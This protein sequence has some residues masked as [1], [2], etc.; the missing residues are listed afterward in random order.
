MIKKFLSATLFGFLALGF[1]GTF[2]ACD[3]Y[4]DSNLRMRVEAVENTLADLQTQI[5]NGAVIKS[6]TSSA[7][8]ITIT[9]MDGKTYNITNGKDGVDGAAGTPGSVVEIGEN[10]NWF[11]DGKDTGLPS[12]GE[13]GDKG[14]KGDQGDK[15][16]QGDKG[17][18]G[19][20]GEAGHT[21]SIYIDPNTKE[22]V[23]DGESTGIVAEGAQG[24]QGAAATIEINDE[25]YWVIN[26]VPT[27]VKAQGEQGEKGEQG[28][29]GAT[30]NTIYYFPYNGN[31]YR[32][33]VTPDGTQVSN[34]DT[35]IS[36]L[37]PGTITAIYDTANQ[38]LT[39]HNVEGATDGIVSIKLSQ[40]L[41]GLILIP[42]VLKD[43]MAVV[44]W[45][46]LQV[47]ETPAEGEPTYKELVASP[48]IELTYRL[49]PSNAKLTKEDYTFAFVES[50]VETRATDSDFTLTPDN[51]GWSV[52]D[53]KL[54]ISAKPSDI[55]V[56]KSNEAY[57]FALQATDAEG[58]TITSDYG[59]LEAG[60]MRDYQITSKP[61]DGISK[62]YATTKPEYSATMQADAEVVCTGELDLNTLVALLET[63][64]VIYVDDIFDVT[65]TFTAEEFLNGEVNQSQYVAIDEKGVLTLTNAYGSVG[66]KPLIK[67]DAKYGETVLATAYL[68]I[69]VKAQDDVDGLTVTAETLNFN[70][71][72][73]TANGEDN[74]AKVFDFATVKAEV[75]DILD[76]AAADFGT[77]YNTTPT[78]EGAYEG[79]HSIMSV[80][81]NVAAL[82]TTE[83]G[84][85]F[86]IFRINNKAK[87]QLE[88]PAQVTVTYEATNANY[89]NVTFV[90]PYVVTDDCDLDNTLP[91]YSG[92][93]E[94]GEYLVIGR[95][96]SGND[97]E[98]AG[99]LYNAYTGFED[100]LESATQIANHTLSFRFKEGVDHTG[101]KLDGDDILTQKVMLENP[102]DKELTCTVELVATLTNGETHPVDELNVRFINPFAMDTPTLEITANGSEVVGE[103]N[104]VLNKIVIRSSSNNAV[105]FEE[106]DATNEAETLFGLESGNFK[107]TY[108]LA[109]GET[110]NFS[111]TSDGTITFNPKGAPVV[112]DWNATVE[113]KVEI[114]NLVIMTGTVNVVV[115]P[116]Q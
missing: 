46:S 47:K 82:P 108:S 91:A 86:I 1:A 69:D 3:D 40:P 34:E 56:L 2:V 59:M 45:Y 92:W 70:Y 116:A 10:G 85:G 32:V 100:W 21:P 78:I 71:S 4:D 50:K 111:V 73:L 24:A 35:G 58:H 61:E 113:V 87:T 39:M 51:E 53:G 17:D 54:S 49:N 18:K 62:T 14:D 31:W 6:V 11:I 74:T 57:I 81:V 33:E 106:G 5:N 115:K 76:I 44:N 114:S 20:T 101:I 64:L 97:Y 28:E 95:M 90:I 26:G 19:D 94:N 75:Y 105:I 27:D 67:V 99:F 25:G 13:K 65:Y 55:A 52:T 112:K 43:G 7:D 104:N 41:A 68:V 98:M 77:Y 60:I 38:V 79:D 88:E 66:M 16:E 36:Y 80:G 22:W 109:S 48:D 102:W 107:F 42:D 93:V 63:N 72:K 8:G 30:P 37:V 29:P 15:G 83:G 9:M 23:I 84:E 103:T 12:R 89:P 96:H 110:N